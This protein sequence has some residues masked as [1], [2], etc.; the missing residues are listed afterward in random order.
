[1]LLKQDWN[2]VPWLYLGCMATAKRELYNEKMQPYTTEPLTTRLKCLDGLLAPYFQ[3]EPYIAIVSFLG[4]F[5][6]YAL[7]WWDYSIS[8]DPS[9]TS[10]IFIPANKWSYIY[11]LP[12]PKDR[13][14]AEAK[15]RFPDV[16][17]QITR[18]T[19]NNVRVWYTEIR[20]A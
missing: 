19:G 5:D 20:T 18:N 16:F 2:V 8:K 15:R 4:N 17:V 12:R 6:Y 1:M 13:I 9:S 11:W 10:T 14:L 7:S 3:D